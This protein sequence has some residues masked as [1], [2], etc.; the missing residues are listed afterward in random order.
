MTVAFYQTKRGI[1]R[2]ADGVSDLIYPGGDI[3][4]IVKG[5]MVLASL[6]SLPLGDLVELDEEVLLLPIRPS[7]F[8]LVGLNYQSHADETGLAQPDTLM[9]GPLEEGLEATLSGDSVRL[10]S[11]APSQVD[12][13]GE[14]AI[15]I[16]RPANEVNPEQA[17]GCIEAISAVIDLSARDVQL[18]AMNRP[19]GVDMAGVVQSKS[20]PGFKPFGPGLQLV[21]VDQQAAIQLETRVNGEIRQAASSADML[22]SIYECVSAISM[23]F[24]LKPGDVIC[25]GT[26]AGVGFVQNLY[27]KDGDEISVNVG[28]LIPLTTRIVSQ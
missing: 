27:L 18:S 28:D 21:D 7:R 9:A 22:F 26:P 10:P 16:G 5:E 11:E 8:Y 3:D 24:E 20:F 17:K 14:I 25:S 19:E 13:E 2:Q 15:V 4:S 1:V 6:A 23:N 12:Y